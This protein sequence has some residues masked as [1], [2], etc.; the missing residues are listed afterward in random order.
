MNTASSVPGPVAVYCPDLGGGVAHIALAQ[1][2]I[3][4]AAGHTVD[5]LLHREVAST[6]RKSPRMF[7]F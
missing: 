2:G 7:A 1:I 6:E 3:L 5:L 4:Q